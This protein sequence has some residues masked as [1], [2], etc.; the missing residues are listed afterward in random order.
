MIQFELIAQGYGLVEVPRV[1]ARK[2]LLF[3]DHLNGGVFRREADGSIR[4]ST[5]WPLLLR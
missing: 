1:D 4:A 2:R 5:R 3:S